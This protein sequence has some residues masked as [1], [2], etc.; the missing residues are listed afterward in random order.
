MMGMTIDFS[1]TV[2]KWRPDKFKEWET[3]GEAKIIIV[4]VSYVV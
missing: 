4:M 3:A 1:E 2:T